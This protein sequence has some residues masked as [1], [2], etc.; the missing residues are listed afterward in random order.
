M[1]SLLLSI[2]WKSERMFL[3]IS[4]IATPEF[5]LMGKL[6]TYT[7]LPFSRLTP[8]KFTSLLHEEK[9]SFTDVTLPEELI[10]DS[11]TLM[12][13]SNLRFC[14]APLLRAYET[15]QLFFALL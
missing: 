4:S 14:T 2:F 15:L 1:I 13:V 8:K 9:L 6:S 3:G 7:P 12:P 11:L 10:I 5:P